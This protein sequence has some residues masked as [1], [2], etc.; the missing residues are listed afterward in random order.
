MPSQA[1]ALPG[2]KLSLKTTADDEAVIA[3]LKTKLPLSYSALLRLGLL[4]L[5]VEQGVWSLPEPANEASHG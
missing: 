2:R 5:A 1:I 3:A 4:R